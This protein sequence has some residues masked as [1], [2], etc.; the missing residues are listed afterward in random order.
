MK[1][2]Y[3][4]SKEELNNC[5]EEVIRVLLR[6]EGPG[7]IRVASRINSDGFVPLKCRHPINNKD[8]TISGAYKLIA[9]GLES[10]SIFEKWNFKQDPGYPPSFE[11][12]FYNKSQNE[13]NI[14]TKISIEKNVNLVDFKNEI[15]KGIMVKIWSFHPARK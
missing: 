4:G 15:F 1:P 11:F 2:Y 7:S 3:I 9:D 8:L 13:K 5:K 12:L 14:Y 6:P 10:Y